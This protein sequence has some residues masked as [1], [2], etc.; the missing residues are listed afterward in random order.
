MNIKT[1]IV[2]LVAAL[3]IT[4]VGFNAIATSAIDLL[5][6]GKQAGEETIANYL[7]KVEAASHRSS[8]IK[9]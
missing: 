9:G 4:L 3:L 6:I 7:A 5:K 8:A 2:I 1:K